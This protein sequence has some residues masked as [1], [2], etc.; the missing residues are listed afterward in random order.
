MTETTTNM[1]FYLYRPDADSYNGFGLRAE[2]RHIIDMH[3]KTEPMLRTWRVPQMH[4]LDDNPGVDG[5]F[6]SLID[7]NMIPL[8]TQRAWDVLNPLIGHCCEALPI[9]VSGCG[10]LYLINVMEIIHCVDETQSEL[11][12][13]AATGRVSR[14]V[15]YFLKT[16]L[17]HGKHIFKTPLQS[18]SDLLISHEV[19]RL[20]EGHGLKG[21]VFNPIPTV[22]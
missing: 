6:P 4:P 10:P 11:V 21:L 17:L 9:M 15:N 14:V 20:V 3:W 1:Q 16:E 19:R 22:D 5:D 12:R 2:D 13:N 7:Y 8:F 18:G